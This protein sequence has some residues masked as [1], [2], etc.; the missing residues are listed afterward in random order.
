MRAVGKE[1]SQ[2]TGARGG[3]LSQ[4]RN[5]ARGRTLTDRSAL[6]TEGRK[7]IKRIDFVIRET[8]LWAE[9]KRGRDYQRSGD[10][11]EGESNG[12]TADAR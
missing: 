10:S 4:G 2:V 5:G 3:S 11:A 8:N 9:L 6:Y 7:M 12:V 1:E